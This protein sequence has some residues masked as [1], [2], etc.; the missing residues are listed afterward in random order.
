MLRLSY[1]IR[2]RSMASNNQR[3][4][5]LMKQGFGDQDLE[6]KVAQFTRAPMLRI[7]VVVGLILHYSVANSDESHLILHNLNPLNALGGYIWALKV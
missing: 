5:S 6:S 2:A 3:R 4:F 1:L 7:E